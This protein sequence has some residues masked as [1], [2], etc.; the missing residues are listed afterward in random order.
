MV[1]AFLGYL[2]YIG[3]DEMNYYRLYLASFPFLYLLAAR[4]LELAGAWLR[5]GRRRGLAVG[6]AGLVLVSA[7]GLDGRETWELRGMG[8]S[9]SSSG[10]SHAAMGVFLAQHSRRGDQV[11]FQDMGLT[12]WV[13][14]Q[15]RFI[16]PIGLVDRTVA[17]AFK[18]AGYHAFLRG[19]FRRSSEGIEIYERLASRLR[20]YFLGRRPEWVA[21]VAYIPPR[22]Y[23]DIAK[24]LRKYPNDASPLTFYLTHEDHFTFD[25]FADARFQEQYRFIR[26]YSRSSKYYLVLFERR[27]HRRSRS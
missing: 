2:L 22:D 6:L 5:V 20:D 1:V 7:A 4:G 21:F 27:D 17:H 12:P 16:D 24:T 9:I 25:L 11:L 13:A 14:E 15:L 3:T 10:K 26:V 23:E 19:E 8:H 18:D